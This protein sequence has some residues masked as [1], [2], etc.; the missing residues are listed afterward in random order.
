MNKKSFTILEG[1]IAA[2][3]AAILFIPLMNSLFV[4]TKITAKD[5]DKIIAFFLANEPIELAIIGNL[6]PIEFYNDLKL[7]DPKLI[8]LWQEI[9]NTTYDQDYYQLYS[10]KGFIRTIEITQTKD[11]LFKLKVTVFKKYPKKNKKL[12]SFTRIYPNKF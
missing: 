11:N 1:L 10:K 8:N 7:S 9:F 5:K 4:S 6:Q 2:T 12:I 3:I